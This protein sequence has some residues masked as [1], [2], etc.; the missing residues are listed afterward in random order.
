VADG[1]PRFVL[2]RGIGQAFTGSAVE[3]A[4]LLALLS[5]AEP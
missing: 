3:P 2:L 4:E 1:R 5:A